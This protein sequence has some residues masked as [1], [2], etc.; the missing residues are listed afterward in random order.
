MMDASSSVVGE[1]NRNDSTVAELRR[2]SRTR[3]AR[4]ERPRPAED[5]VILYRIGPVS[6]RVRHELEP[7][8]EAF[9]ANVDIQAQ[10]R[11]AQQNASE[12]MHLQETGDEC[13]YVAAKHIP[14]GTRLAAYS[15]FVR[16][17]KPGNTRRRHDVHLG[18]PGIGCKLILDGSPGLS[19]EDDGRPGRLQMLD[20]ACSPYNNCIETRMICEDSMLPAY[21]VDSIRDIDAG[22]LITFE[23]QQV[24]RTQ[25]RQVFYSNDFWQNAA[26]LPRPRPDQK[27]IVCRCAQHLGQACPNGYGRLEPRSRRPPPPHPSTPIHPSPTPLLPLPTF[28]RPLQLTHPHH[29][30]P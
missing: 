3:A 9:H 4:R 18:D 20:H 10:C 6:R 24:H 19:V 23:Y 7:L 27:L 26:T 12:Y 25:G 13:S 21:F 28:P 8:L 22:Q 16:E 1:A 11:I 30:R 15:G 14:A 17:E 29:H 2:S 5:A